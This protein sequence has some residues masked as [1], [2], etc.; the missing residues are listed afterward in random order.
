LTTLGKAHLKLSFRPMVPKLLASAV[1][2]FVG[3]YC[4]FAMSLLRIFSWSRSADTARHL[5]PSNGWSVG[6]LVAAA[7]VV[8]LAGCSKPAPV[9]EPIRSVKVVTV[10]ATK[11]ESGAE[12]AGEVRARVE[13]RFGFRV[14]GKLMQRAVEPGQRVKAGQLLAQLDARDY[15]LAAEAAKAQVSAAAT[16]RN[17]SVAEFKRFSELKDQNF[18]SGAELDRRDAA[19]KAAEAQLEQ[20]QAQ[21]SSQR[22]Q[23]GYTK[24]TADVAGVVLG[25][26][27]E[28]GQVV[29]AG[30]TIVRIAKDGPR[31]VLFSVPEDRVALVTMGSQV[32]V[33]PWSGAS[34]YKGVVREIAASADP[35]T[36]TFQIKVSMDGKEAAEALALGSTVNVTPRAL[37]LAGIEVIKLPTSALKREGK[38][39]TVWVVDPASM[40][41]KSQVV[42]IVTAEG[43][44]VV[45]ASGV[46]PGMLV[47]AAGVHVLHAGQKVTLYKDKVAGN[48]ATGAVPVAKAMPAV[49]K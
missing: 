6:W 28:A 3:N 36:R 48:V 18:I 10:S 5:P 25:V 37:S 15:L 42:E 7:A 14:A 44:E 12:Y 31:D 32:E 19:V 49:S 26:D 27:A 21:L 1:R 38:S 20:A 43:N 23:T 29:A 16:N 13:S 22:N 45:V 17:L 35:V 40:T 46:S 34:S 8:A 9:Q 39:T 24:L 47:V 11:M 2:P 41:V 30:Q 4:E 33:R